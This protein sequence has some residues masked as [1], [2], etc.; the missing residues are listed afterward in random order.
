M[1]VGFHFHFIPSLDLGVGLLFFFFFGLH[2]SDTS[3][4]VSSR[5]FI[6][7]NFFC[8]DVTWP[9]PENISQQAVVFYILFC[10]GLIY[11]LFLS[12]EHEVKVSATFLQSLAVIH[13]NFLSGID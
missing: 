1:D 10:L 6:F 2:V 4:V 11:G 5:V 3:W 7:S 8:M 9:S 12:L 13:S